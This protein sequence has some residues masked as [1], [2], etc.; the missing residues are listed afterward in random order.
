[1]ID[2]LART[3]VLFLLCFC[4]VPLILF[5]GITIGNAVGRF[6]EWLDSDN[7]RRTHNGR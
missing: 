1:M 5:C 3:I 7:D 4:V 6:C 2:F